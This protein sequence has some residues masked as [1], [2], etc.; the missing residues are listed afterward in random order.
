MR[1]S[2]ERAS[3][4]CYFTS[5][6][7]YFRGRGAGDLGLELDG[8]TLFLSNHFNNDV[9]TSSSGKII[10]S[11]RHAEHGFTC[12]VNL[13]DMYMACRVLWISESCFLEPEVD[14]M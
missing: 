1:T 3:Q 10:T 9:I 8:Q 2:L 11:C 14:N 7:K 13:R 4:Q 12:F 6:L 5:G